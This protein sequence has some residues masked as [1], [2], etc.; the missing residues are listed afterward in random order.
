M[1]MIQAENG[2]AN[3]LFSHQRTAQTAATITRLWVIEYKVSSHSGR[4]ESGGLPL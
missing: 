1:W 4:I 3:S 2:T